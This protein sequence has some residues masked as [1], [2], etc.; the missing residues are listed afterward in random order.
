MIETTI[1]AAA[2]IL[3]A[4]LLYWEKRESLRGVLFTK[5][6]LSA[7][8]VAVALAGPRA[9]P[10]YS[11][12]IRVGLLFCLAGDVFLIFSSSRRLFLAGVASFLIAHILYV[13]AFSTVSQPGVVTWIVSACAVALSGAFF[14]WLRPHLGTMLFPILAYI[15]VITA[16]VVS[17]ASLWESPS[18]DLFGRALAFAGAL[19]FYCSD[20]F[21]ARQR[22]VVK[23][24]VNRLVGLPLYY[25]AQFMIAFSIRFL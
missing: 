5:P 24:H 15:V 23:N 11:G 17:A 13:A 25:S 10:S 9:D 2:M 14:L 7:L 3:L 21:V 22:F 8:F 18:R 19:F 12:L 6:L 20:L 4:A 16:M 1:L